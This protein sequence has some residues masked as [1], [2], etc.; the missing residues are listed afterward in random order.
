MNSANSNQGS[1]QN[2]RSLSESLAKSYEVTLQDP[3]FLRMK[4]QFSA[5]FNF[6]VPGAMKL[7][8]LIKKLK[9]WIKIF[10]AKTKLQPKYRILLFYF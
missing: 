8:N 7:Q 5:E 9:K 2:S 4:E 6:S 10:E 3:T 1:N